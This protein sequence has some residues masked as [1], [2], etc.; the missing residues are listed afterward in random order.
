MVE[1]PET[2]REVTVAGEDVYPR[3]R[4]HLAEDV[5]VGEG[6]APIGVTEPHIDWLLDPAHLEAPR[7]HESPLIA[8]HAEVALPSRFGK[9]DHRSL[10]EGRVSKGFYI[11]RGEAWSLQGVKPAEEFC[12]RSLKRSLS[13]LD[14]VGIPR[15]LP[16]SKA[17]AQ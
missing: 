13:D 17:R 15:R 12:P 3:V 1:N 6:D 16:G 9:C 10:G 2:D 8:G 11:R 4:E 7:S 14:V 5:S